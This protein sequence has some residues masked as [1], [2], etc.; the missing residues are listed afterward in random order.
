MGKLFVL[1]NH[2]INT[3]MMRIPTTE[4]AVF[5]HGNLV[6]RRMI[7][8]ISTMGD[9]LVNQ[10]HHIPQPIPQNQVHNGVPQFNAGRANNRFRGEQIQFVDG[11][12]QVVQGAPIQGV[13]G[14]CRPV[15]V[16]N[17]SAIVTPV[18]NNNRPFEVRPQYLGHLPEFYG[19]RTEEPY[20]HI[21]SFDSICQT[22][23]VPGFT[24]DEVKLMLFQ[25]TLK[26]K[27]RQWFTTLPP[28]SIY[29][30]QEMQLLFLEEYYTMNRTSEARDAIRAFQQHSG[31]PFHEA[32]TRFKE[33]LRKCL[34][35]EIQ[36]W[37]LIKAFYDGLLPDDVRDLIAISNGT[38]LTNTEAADWAYLERQSATSKRQAQSSRRARS[39]SAK[40]VDYEAEERVEKLRQQNLLLER[41]VAQMNLGKGGEV[42]PAN[43]FA[44]CTEC[45][46]LGHQVGECVVLG[47]QTEE[48]NQLYGEQKQYDMKSNTYHPGLRNHPNFS[49]GNSANQ[50]NPNFQVPNQGG[51]QY[52]NRQGN[53][54]QGGYQ[55][56]GQYNQGPQADNQQQNQ[57]NYQGSWRN[58]GNQQGNSSGGGGDSSDLKLDAIMSFMKDIQ[59]DNEVRDKT[60]EAMQKQ[61]GIT[62]T[63]PSQLVEEVV[64]DV[65]N[66]SDSQH[67]R[68][69][70]RD[71]R[72]ESFKQA[73][74][75]LPLLDAIKEN[76]DQVEFLKELST[77]KRLHKFPKKLDLTANVNA[78]LLG[79]LPPKL[80]DPGAPIISV[81][82]GEFKIESAL[83][84][85][86][87]CV[88]ILPGSLYDQYDFG[89]LQKVNTTVVL[90]DQTPMCPR[91]IVRDVIVKVEDCYYPVDF[92]VLDCATSSKNTHSPVI[93]GT[94]FLATAHAII[95]CVDGTVSMKFGDRELRLNV[96]SNATDPL[97][98]GEHSKAE[99]G[100][101]K[102]EVAERKAVRKKESVAHEKFK[103]NKGKPRG[104]KKEK[105]P[106]ECDNAKQRLKLFGPM[107]NTVDDLLEHWRGTYLE[108]VG[109]KH[110]TRP[111]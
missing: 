41:Q 61:L 65:G 51:Q 71:E 105:K 17:S 111:P 82:V 110:P 26:D 4:K 8:K 108:A 92:L 83:S 95:N 15:V 37:E 93:L 74:I 79:T 28:G 6:G 87:A 102:F 96:F 106:P 48:V 70:P 36:T 40:S 109:R 34:H 50:L 90:A 3:G 9:M 11:V 53:Y 66:R 81:Q 60:L 12:P 18:G 23:G 69:P 25:F 97:I 43:T 67:D 46:E 94:P 2:N 89:L 55:N 73:K 88:S 31:E 58:Q 100:E 49:Y 56:R 27:A 42:K 7:T 44:V 5:I 38:F 84:D 76:P 85:L 107:W 57:G 13:E 103:T 99:S 21:A 29:T 1:T 104:R 80:Q 77:Q 20:L 47:G 62:I 78:V 52:Q 33:L 22:I 10:R 39:S 98:T 72:W 64:E 30:W 91:G 24:K 54:Q 86:G 63:P 101:G 35:H 32:F 75:N 19:K 68:D 14:H 16:P 59:K 45:G